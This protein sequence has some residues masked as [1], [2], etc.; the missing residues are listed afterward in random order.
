MTSAG[1]DGDRGGREVRLAFSIL[2]RKVVHTASG[3]SLS[4]QGL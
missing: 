2:S 1:R 4:F 3:K